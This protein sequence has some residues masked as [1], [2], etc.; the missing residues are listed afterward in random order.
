MRRRLTGQQPPQDDPQAL[1]AAVPVSVAVSGV[2][3]SADAAMAPTPSNTTT[4][5]P[6]NINNST[7][8]ATDTVTSSPTAASAGAGFLDVASL[9]RF[10][11]DDYGRPAQVIY[12]RKIAAGAKLP[13]VMVLHAW[14][15]NGSYHDAYLGVSARANQYGFIALLPD[16][17]QNSK[18]TCMRLRLPTHSPSSYARCFSS[19][20]PPHQTHPS[21]QHTTQAT[22]SGPLPHAAIEK[23]SQSTTSGTSPTS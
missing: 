22:V 19:T 3:P 5:G 9:P 15:S 18:G 1:P 17:M 4:M 2:L 6:T 23:T 14:G 8:I 10:V 21:K 13:V 20:H 16:G 12:P 7:G 11:G